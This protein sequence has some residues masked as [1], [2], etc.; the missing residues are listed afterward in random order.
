M[1][2]PR[3]STKQHDLLRRE[4]FA[5]QPNLVTLRESFNR[6]F[7]KAY[8]QIE[9]LATD[10]QNFSLMSDLRFTAHANYAQALLEGNGSPEAA[11]AQTKLA[12][13]DLPP[14]NFDAYAGNVQNWA[15]LA[16]QGIKQE[17]IP[18]PDY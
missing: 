14:Q 3:T 17:Q 13:Q 4:L 1:I 7:Y 11:A 10:Q 18:K 2:D 16:A 9:A 5:S 15:L 12:F 6:R 8:D